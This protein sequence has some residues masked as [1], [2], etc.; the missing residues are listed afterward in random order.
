MIDRLTDW[1]T[2]IAGLLICAVII[3]ALVTRPEWGATDL[4]AFAGAIGTAV[5]G[6]LSRSTAGAPAPADAPKAPTV[7]PIV[8]A[9]LFGAGV[10]M[11]AAGPVLAGCTPTAQ[12]TAAQVGG[13]ALAAVDGPA[14]EF[15]EVRS[16]SALA[17]VLCSGAA[18][19][20]TGLLRGLGSTSQ[21]LT[22]GDAG[23]RAA[24]R[25]VPV[26]AGGAHQGFV[27]AEH[28][29]ALVAALARDGGA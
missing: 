19:A 14:C 13:A 10:G 17:G 22:S 20:L 8:G 29:S 4:A 21:A 6:A 11:L 27:C 26:H 12:A 5:L 3:A 7:P 1:K 23:A 16:G 15:V 2:T 9:M 25:L 18:G 24:C 28:E